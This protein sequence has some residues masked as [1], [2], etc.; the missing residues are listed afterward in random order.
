MCLRFGFVFRGPAGFRLRLGFVFRGLASFRFLRRSKLRGLA[1]R[2]RLAEAT[3]LL[4][5]RHV[6]Q[7]QAVALG[8]DGKRQP[9]RLGADPT[10]FV[11]TDSAVAVGPR[12]IIWYN[13]I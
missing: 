2:L 13:I 10:L 5:R 6:H 3:K 12:L 11:L 1:C 7:D 8:R 9:Q 4:T